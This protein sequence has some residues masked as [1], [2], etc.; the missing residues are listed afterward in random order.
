[1]AEKQ[2]ITIWFRMVDG[3][4]MPIEGEPQVGDMFERVEFEGERM[5]SSTIG[6]KV[7]PEASPKPAAEAKAWDEGEDAGDAPE[8][9]PEELEAGWLEEVLTGE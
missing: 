8:D 4:K 3:E 9:V 6:V 2:E 1:M 7:A 5:L